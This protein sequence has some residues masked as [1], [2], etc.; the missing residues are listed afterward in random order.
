MFA[1]SPMLTA[2]KKVDTSKI[3]RKE[4]STLL[5]LKIHQ[6][7]KKGTKRRRGEREKYKNHTQ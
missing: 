2:K 1:K 6:N 7:T 5:F 4:P 3:K